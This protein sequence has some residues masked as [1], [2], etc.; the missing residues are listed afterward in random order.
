MM[1][2]QMSRRIQARGGAV[3]PP[4]PENEGVISTPEDPPPQQELQ[5]HKR[6]RRRLVSLGERRRKKR[7]RRQL[8]IKARMR[9]DREQEVAA[10]DNLFGMSEDEIQDEDDG[11]DHDGALIVPTF[12]HRPLVEALLPGEFISLE[13]CVKVIQSP[14]Q[15]VSSVRAEVVGD[16]FKTYT[17]EIPSNVVRVMGR[18][19]SQSSNRVTCSVSKLIHT[20]IPKKVRGGVVTIHFLK[21]PTYSWVTENL[22]EAGYKPPRGPVDAHS[23]LF[24]RLLKGEPRTITGTILRHDTVRGRMA[25]LDASLPAGSNFRWVDNRTITQ[26]I[27]GRTTFVVS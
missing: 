11:E 15:A 8:E 14:S 3:V 10:N 20:I 17:I 6:K 18:S 16:D 9:H 24:K 23:T 27:W 21:A 12:K 25:M 4:S 19:A 22:R 5:P 13:G 2:R 26:M 1:T 7:H